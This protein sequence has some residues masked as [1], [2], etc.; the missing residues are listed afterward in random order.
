MNQPPNLTP[1]TARVDH[2]AMLTR[3]LKIRMSCHPSADWFVSLERVNER[4]GYVP[5]NIA[6][7]CI[8]VNTSSPWTEDIA[9]KVRGPYFLRGCSIVVN[10]QRI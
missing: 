3:Y 6:L 4:L 9:D 8:E 2:G 5:S 10:C 1:R 7:V